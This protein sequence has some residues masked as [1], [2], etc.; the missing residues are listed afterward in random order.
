MKKNKE[1]ATLVIQAEML[2]DGENII[3]NPDDNAGLDV[4][5]KEE[6]PNIVDI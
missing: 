5:R 6:K 4:W 2:V 3:D 1:S